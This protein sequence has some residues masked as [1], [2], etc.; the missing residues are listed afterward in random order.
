MTDAA[1][2]SSLMGAREIAVRM[3]LSRQRIQQLAE[4]PDFPAPV[5]SLRMGRVWRTTEIE[6]WLRTYRDPGERR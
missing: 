6:S 5:A 4:R 2:D 1:A 3:G